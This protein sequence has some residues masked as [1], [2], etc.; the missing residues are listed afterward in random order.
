MI[1]TAEQLLFENREYSNPQCRIQAMVKKGEIFSL[2]RGLYETDGNV[3]GYVLANDIFGP[4]YI[5]FEYAL[6]YYGMIPERVITYTSAT[7]GKNRRKKFENHFG[8][9]SYKDIPKAVFPKYFTRETV[10]ERSFLIASREK[11]LCDQ[12]CVLPPIRGLA[13]FEE[14]L[15]E[16]MRLD[17]DIYD[18]LD[19]DKIRHIAPLYHRTN[20]DQ[21]LRLVDKEGK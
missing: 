9:F 8:I 13:D 14:Y 2:K 4:S 18:E 10:G 7:L 5:S 12:L 17:E 6:S 16:G 21:L 15:F 3:P 19:F 11:A 20:L 1:V